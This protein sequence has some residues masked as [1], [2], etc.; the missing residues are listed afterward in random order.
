MRYEQE[1]EREREREREKDQ[2]WLSLIDRQL[3]LY[4]V[5]EIVHRPYPQLEQGR[6]GKRW[7]KRRRREGRRREGRE[8]TRKRSRMQKVVSTLSFLISFIFL[9]RVF[10]LVPIL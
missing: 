10:L 8:V 4:H 1:R 3:E 5:P 2:E 6:R 7:R 9:W